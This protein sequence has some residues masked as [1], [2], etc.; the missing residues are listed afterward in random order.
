MDKLDE[1]NMHKN[2]KGYYE[3]AKQT[4]G[5]S[6]MN[7][8]KRETGLPSQLLL[9]VKSPGAPSVLVNTEEKLQQRCHEHFSKLLN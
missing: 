9:K 4:Y 6:Y 3:A 8:G 5:Y 1:A 2:G 7:A